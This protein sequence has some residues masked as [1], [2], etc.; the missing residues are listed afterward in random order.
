MATDKY[1]RQDGLAGRGTSVGLFFST[2]LP[3]FDRNQGNVARVREE[4]RQAD[5]RVR[6]L[7]QV[8]AGEVELAAAQ[9]AAAE[10]TLQTVEADM[11][12]EARDVRAITDYA[13]RRGQATLIELLDAQR[14][15]NETMQA[16]NEA[17]AE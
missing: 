13:Y 9:Y 7:E 14:A 17:R 15:F 4:E 11:L 8:I 10:A 6:R 2:P 5:L 12:T 1:R 3:L 16:W